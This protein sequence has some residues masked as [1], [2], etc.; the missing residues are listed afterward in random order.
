MSGSQEAASA[1]AQLERQR[2]QARQAVL[3]KTVDLQNLREKR[4]G[5]EL[6]M[7]KA[8]EEIAKASQELGH[9]EGTIAAMRSPLGYGGAPAESYQPPRPNIGPFVDYRTPRRHR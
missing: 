2:E 6:E 1:I 4:Y 9:I 3:R 5:I 7:Q 8:Q